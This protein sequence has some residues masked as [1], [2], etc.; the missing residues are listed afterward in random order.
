[1]SQPPGRFR[2]AGRADFLCSATWH[3]VRLHVTPDYGPVP[4][5][6]AQL[7]AA[8]IAVQSSRR[9]R[10]GLS[11][12]LRPFR[13]CDKGSAARQEQH[14]DPMSARGDL[15]SERSSP[16]RNTPMPGPHRKQ[17]SPCRASRFSLRA[18]RKPA[19]RNGARS[20][21]PPPVRRRVPCAS[22]SRW[23]SQTGR[24]GPAATASASL[25]RS[26]LR[27]DSSTACCDARPRDTGSNPH[28]SGSRGFLCLCSAE[29]RSRRRIS[30]S[31]V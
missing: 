9:G 31:A 3:W 23:A 8:N 12:G 4:S 14:C 24:P 25:P 29:T 20:R 18:Q 16:P 6:A 7:T 28:H 30:G 13:A 22:R 19:K 2:P 11:S 26:A 17:V 10:D 27:A 15:H 1:M 21:G 5:P